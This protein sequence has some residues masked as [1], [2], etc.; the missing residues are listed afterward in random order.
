MDRTEYDIRCDKCNKYLFTEIK[1]NG[2]IKREKD[3]NNYVY[4]DIKDEFVCDECRQ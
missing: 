1:E 4:D 2:K 3:K